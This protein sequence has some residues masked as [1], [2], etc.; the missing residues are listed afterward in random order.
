MRFQGGNMKVGLTLAISAVLAPWA[1]AQF[2][3]EVPLDKVVETTL[4]DVR[5]HPDAYKGVWVRFPV[6]FCSIGGVAAAAR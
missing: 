4:D 3:T 1:N 2:Q 6:Q 5:A